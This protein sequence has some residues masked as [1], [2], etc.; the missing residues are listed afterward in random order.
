MLKRQGNDWDNMQ[1][2]RLS[3]AAS[4]AIR[5]AMQKHMQHGHVYATDRQTR[6]ILDMEV[7]IEE[8]LPDAAFDLRSDN[9]IR[10]Q[11]IVIEA[12]AR[13]FDVLASNNIHS[14]DHE[15]LH[16]WIDKEG[17]KMGII[18][19]VLRPEEAER[20]L[21]EAYNKPLDWTAHALARACVTDPENPSQSAH[22]MM[23]M[24]AEFN[25]RGMG[26]IRMRIEKV[27]S[28]NPEFEKVLDSVRTHG[29]SHAAQTEREIETA[30]TNTVSKKSG[31]SILD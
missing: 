28:N 13:G 15:M 17:S 18:S 31:I 8:K 23:E 9:G 3:T 4:V 29:K 27:I 24:L 14:V 1:L 26:G 16:D 20:K 10:D 19:D 11:K 25:E 7:A 30:S 12:L 2:R 22:E 21:R 5:D 6:R